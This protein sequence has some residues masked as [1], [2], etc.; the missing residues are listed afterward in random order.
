MESA[1]IG[2]CAFP[3]EAACRQ[4]LDPVGP[5]GDAYEVAVV[6]EP[7]G[8]GGCRHRIAEDIG[9]HAY[10]HV[11][12]HDRRPPLVPPGDKLEDEAGPRLS[13]CR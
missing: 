9:P 5:S 8:Y 11:R 3:R 1:G 2:A 6:A 10:P 7:V 12:R 4:V 13:I